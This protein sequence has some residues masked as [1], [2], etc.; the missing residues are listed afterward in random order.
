MYCSTATILSNA[1]ANFNNEHVY[2][3][4]SLCYQFYMLIVVVYFFY[5]F[6][7]VADE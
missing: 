6:L 3:I 4:A 1:C 2:I 5:K 7:V